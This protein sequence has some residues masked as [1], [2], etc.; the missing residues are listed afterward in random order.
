MWD[1]VDYLWEY[2]ISYG[3]FLGVYGKAHIFDPE[4]YF[5]KIRSV[6]PSPVPHTRDFTGSF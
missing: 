6:W 2:H 3:P 5:C 1:N 4:I